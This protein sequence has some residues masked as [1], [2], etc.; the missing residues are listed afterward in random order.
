MFT[1]RLDGSV[2]W[3]ALPTLRDTAPRTHARLANEANRRVGTAHQMAKIVQTPRMVA[4]ASTGCH[5]NRSVHRGQEHLDLH[6]ICEYEWNLSC[7]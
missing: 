3:W 6:P 4:W 5:Q 1:L 2:H 7:H